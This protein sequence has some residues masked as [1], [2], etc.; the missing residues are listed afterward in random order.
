MSTRQSRRSSFLVVGLGLLT[1]ALA[2]PP[3]RAQSCTTDTECDFPSTTCV[4]GTCQAYISSCAN[5]SQRNPAKSTCPEPSQ[6][7]T[8]GSA[9]VPNSSAG[10]SLS[11]TVGDPV[12]ADQG[13]LIRE[14]KDLETFGNAPITFAR[15]YNSRTLTFNADYWDFGNQQTWQHNW[16]YEMRQLSSTTFG[17]FDI[18]VRYPDG[19]EYNFK[20]TDAGGEQLAPAVDNGDRLYRWPGQT[21][22]YTMITP[23]GWEFHFQRVSSPKFRMLEVRDGQGAYW[24]LSH[25]ANGKI[26]KIENPYGRFIEITR[27]TVSGVECITSVATSDGREVTYSYDTWSPTGKPVLVG[28]GYPGTEAASYTWVGAD[29]ETT[30]RPLLASAHDPM[31][32]GPNSVMGFEY[33]YDAIFEFDGNNFLVTGVILREVH[34]VSEVEVVSLPLGPGE[35]P[36]ILEGSGAEVHRYFVNGLLAKVA[37]A[38]GRVTSF[39]RTDDGFGCLESMTEPNGAVTTYTRDFANRPLT[40]T[41]GYDNVR[42]YDYN[43]GGFLVSFTDEEGNTTEYTRDTGNR[44]TRVDHPDL[45]FETWT[46]DANGNV[47][48]HQARSGGVTTYSYYEAEEE[49]GLTGDLKTVTDPLDGE[50]TYTHD[51]AGRVLTRTDQFGHITSYTYNARGRVVGVEFADET[52]IA[53]TYDE[54][55]NPI[56]LMNELEEVWTLDYNEF[57]RLASITDPLEGTTTF[58]YGLAPDDTS[59]GYVG[60]IARITQASGRVVE[61]TYNADERIA[62]K[63]LAPGTADEATWSWSYNAEGEVET[64][65]DPL[66]NVTTF[67]FD[68]LH[69]LASTTDPLLNETTR[70]YDDV[71]NVV[72]VTL[73]DATTIAKVY[74]SMQRLISRTDALEQVTSFDYEDGN[75]ATITDA[76]SQV[77]TFGYD[78]LDRRTRLTFPDESFEEWSYDAAGSLASFT[79]RAGQVRTHTYDVRNREI[80]RDWSDSTADMLK[81]YDAA[82]RLLSLSTGVLAQGALSS[83]FTELSYS[84]DAAGRSISET[85]DVSSSDADFSAFTTGY[86]HDEDGQIAEITYSSSPVVSF[87]RNGRGAIVEVWAGAAWPL[88]EYSYD[89]AGR[90]TGKTLENGTETTYDYDDAG[91]LLS[92]AHTSGMTTVASFEYTHDTLGRR[93]SMES[94]LPGVSARVDDYT[95]D[96]IGRIVGVEYGI[97]REVTYSLDEV[98]NRLSVDD[99]VAGVTD[100]TVN[101][102]NQYTTIEPPSASLAVAYDDNGNLTSDETWTYQYDAESRLISAESCTRRLT[103]LYDGRNR[104]VL[105]TEY[106]PELPEVVISQIYGAGGNTGSTLANDFVELHN[107]GK[108]AVSLSGWS[109]Q[110]ASSTG[111]SWAKTNLSGSI[112]AGGFF[113]IQLHAGAQGGDPLPTPDTTGNTNLSATTGKVALSSS[114]TTLSGTCPAGTEVVNLIGYGSSASCYTG[115]APAPAPASATASISRG[116]GACAF[117]EDSTDFTSGTASPRNSASSPSSCDIWQEADRYALVYSGWHLIEEYEPFDVLRARYIHGPSTDEI[118]VRSDGSNDRYLHHDGLGSVVA[119]TGGAG[120]AVESYSYDVYGTVAAYDSGGDPLPSPA[121]WSRFLYTGREWLEAAGVYDYRNRQ[122]SAD[123]GRFLQVDPIRFMGGDINLYVYVGNSPVDYDDPSGLVITG[124]DDTTMAR[125]EGDKTSGEFITRMANDPDIEVRFDQVTPWDDEE[126]YYST[127]A[128][129]GAKTSQPRKETCGIT[130]GC[131]CEITVVDIKYSMTAHSEEARNRGVDALP[132]DAVAAHEL[133]HAYANAYREGDYGKEIALAWES[134]V[135]GKPKTQHD[136]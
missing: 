76:K 117:G 65:T 66:E 81:S 15:I 134:A 86:D 73:P 80:T 99:S 67:E 109:I 128:L 3:S 59:T 44:I 125:L 71:G 87:E 48:T 133:G 61:I 72:L 93:A 56:E 74:D 120:S 112:A 113:L 14:V 103:T 36:Q 127:K 5:D 92:I 2:A 1:L 6:Q 28:V 78:A 22:G 23:Q 38:G 31:D 60:K 136:Q 17:F 122:Y 16:N 27:G 54:F 63:V 64:I 121:S 29:S 25:D 33:N 98:G 79:T 75:L 129:G 42:T 45:T 132:F 35:H 96:D 32:G 85:S 131:S 100:Y 108:C 62:T 18:K 126:E 46:Y 37:D 7:P 135:T 94:T 107:R 39:T 9:A 11:P 124:L 77:H 8:T 58:E 57:Q 4:A 95:Y 130:R 12:S 90:R 20:A 34:P 110:Y 104:A 123:L 119:I 101:A 43:D 83:V 116:G 21:I 69:R 10:T 26:T 89:L 30:G 82:G 115:T 19:R 70:A 47:L 88:A 52:T 68:L 91:R 102:L 24:T 40:V 118:L 84:Y 13:N 55:G 53:F 97:T 50:V 51:E 41:D 106:D 111:S 49:G 114:T 105:R